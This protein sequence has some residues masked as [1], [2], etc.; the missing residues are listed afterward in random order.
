MKK[1]KSVIQYECTT[2]FKYIWLF[3]GI[4]YAVVALVTLIIG[5]S[6]GT[7]EGIGTDVIEIHSLIYVGVLG[8]LG[9]NQDFK[10]L[11]QLSLIHI[12]GN[13]CAGIRY[14]QRQYTGR[15]DDFSR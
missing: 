10:M 7:F 4:Q 15:T 13:E 9:F 14:C 6:T 8:V 2:S 3:Y 5:I 1:L 11:L 12:Y